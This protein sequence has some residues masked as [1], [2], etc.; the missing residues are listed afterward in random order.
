MKT[1]LL[2]LSILSVLSLP[3]KGQWSDTGNNLTTGTL[4]VGVSIPYT[5]KQLYVTANNTDHV[6]VFEN[7]DA[8]GNGVI[9]S[10]AVDPLRV[11]G[12]GA[13]NGNLMIVKGNGN[14]GIGTTSP[15]YK[16]DV[17]GTTWLGGA[18]YVGGTVTANSYL[19][20]S[21]QRFKKN[22]NSDYNTYQKLY[23]I[24]I[25]EYQYEDFEPEKTHY[26][27]I[28]QELKEL[29]PNMVAGD[30]EKGLSVNYAEMIPLLIRAVQD[31][32]QTIDMLVNEVSTLKNEL[33][34]NQKSK[35]P[36]EFKKE[37]MILYPNPSSS[38]VKISFKNKLENSTSSI[39][40][41]NLNGEVIQTIAR[42]GRDSIELTN[43]K[44]QKGV[45][46]VRYISNGELIATKRMIIEK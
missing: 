40:V 36:V 37:E 11:S 18:T 20:W 35:N 5:T 33:A 21:D 32:K 26:G 24:K 14:V 44:L 45:Y 43:E 1:T 2:L 41:V 16:L 10:A 31:Q 23:K 9:I 39:E 46:F 19:T 34:E 28:A 22:I 29:L 25:Y 30:D 38:S 3:L 8:F 12:Y 7:I 13:L 17:N 42:S 15:S 6:S 4:R 27:V